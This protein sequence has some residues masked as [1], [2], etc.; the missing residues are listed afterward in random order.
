VTFR[1]LLGLALIAGMPGIA[2]AQF[3]TFI[4][5]VNKAADS[6]KAAVVAEQ[7]VQQD[8]V[9]TAQITNMKTW[10]DSAAGIMPTPTTAVD[11]MGVATTTTTT[12]TTT[13]ADSAFVNGSRAPATASMLPLLLL[14]GLGFIG[15]GVAVVFI[16]PPRE[17]A[18]VRSQSRRV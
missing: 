17:R 12:T 13:A 18:R 14:V 4:P 5:P 10:V 16:Q 1:S 7:K 15:A 8:S 9:A 3:T 11:S 2:R 6:V